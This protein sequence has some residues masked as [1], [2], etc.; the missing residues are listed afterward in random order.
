MKKC[1]FVI[2]ECFVETA[3]AQS[4]LNCDVNHQ[5]GCNQVSRVMQIKYEN[6]FAIGMIDNDK[7]HSTYVKEAKEI[8]HSS[9]VIIKKLQDKPHYFV[10][11]N[12]AMEKFMIDV[13]SNGLSLK[14][15]NLPI[16]LEGL[17]SITKDSKGMMF[18]A[19][20]RRFFADKSNEENSE[21]HSLK[22]LLCYLCENKYNVKIEEVK[23][24]LE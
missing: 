15:Y 7:R 12:P 18:N 17:K 1:D 8:C 21:M 14:G 24:F 13:S 11:I 9:H 4:F 19:D 22:K 20:I 23:K 16:D 5:K 6:D 3:M 10:V 2:P